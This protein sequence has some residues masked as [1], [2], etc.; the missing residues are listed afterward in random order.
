[1]RKTAR[2]V[3]L[4]RRLH[5]DAMGR[6]GDEP[7]MVAGIASIHNWPVLMYCRLVHVSCKKLLLTA[8]LTVLV[9]Y[10]E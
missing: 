4:S 8:D 5:T 6:V 10:V 1:M 7:T 9:S 2:P 3:F